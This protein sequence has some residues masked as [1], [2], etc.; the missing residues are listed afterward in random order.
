MTVTDP[1]KARSKNRF[2]AFPVGFFL[3]AIIGICLAIVAAAVSGCRTLSDIRERYLTS[4]AHETFRSV[5]IQ[6]RR[7]SRPAPGAGLFRRGRRGQFH[8]PDFWQAVL[9]EIYPEYD[10][11]VVFLAVV[12]TAGGVVADAGEPPE[13][14][15]R[16]APGIH[17]LGDRSIFIFETD[18]RPPPGGP[19]RRHDRDDIGGWRFRVGLKTE[20]ADFIVRLGYTYAALSA[21]AIVTLI[22]LTSVFLRTLRRFIALQEHEK[23]QRHLTALG[24]MGATLAHEI[25][26]PLGAIKGLTQVVQEDL[27]PDHSAHASLTTVVR[28]TQRLEQLVTD[29][30]EYAKPGNVTTVKINVNDMA[31]EVAALV[32]YRATEV[33]VTVRVGRNDADPV[34]VSDERGLRQV[35]LN[36]VINAVEMSAAGDAVTVSNRID[37][38]DNACVIEVTDAG[39]GL[40]D[41]NPEEFFEPF[42]TTRMKGAGLGLSIARKI[43]DGLGGTISLANNVKRGARCVITVPANRSSS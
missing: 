24:K 30:L 1:D 27:P 18:F 6:I 33:G 25:R 32:A 35:L 12:D 36:V 4:L 28:E 39:Q 23:S 31:A 11:Q 29:L 38:A 3:V 15:A 13:Q 16:H 17:R 22:V 8:D 34:I 10:G 40:G 26:N 14:Y 20:P 21:V 7:H 37:M 43:V 2:G 5:F 19:P 9:D 41:R 42:V